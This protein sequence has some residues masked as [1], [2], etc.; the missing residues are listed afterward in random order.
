M[1][2]RYLDRAFP[3]AA[4]RGGPVWSPGGYA[5]HT[6]ILLL[7]LVVAGVPALHTQSASVHD[8]VRAKDLASVKRLV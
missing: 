2:I 5:M 6:A 4:R 7:A 3:P 1:L 8:A